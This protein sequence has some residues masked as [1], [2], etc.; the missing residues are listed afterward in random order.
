MEAHP[1]HLKGKQQTAVH[2]AERQID[3]RQDVHAAV[4]ADVRAVGQA[5]DSRH[6]VAGQLL[7]LVNMKA[8]DVAAAAVVGKGLAAV[9]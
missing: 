4:A 7:R 6:G 5:A 2:I 1:G 3:G 9:H 8:A